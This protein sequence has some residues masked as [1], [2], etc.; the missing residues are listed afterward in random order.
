MQTD[1]WPLLKLRKSIWRVLIYIHLFAN[2]I[3]STKTFD[4]ISIFVILLNSLMM[5][6][7]DPAETEPEKIFVLIDNIF[8]TLYSIEM[9]LKIVGLG[10][11]FSKKAY[12]KESWNILDFVIVISGYL[13]LWTESN[14]KD[15]DTGMEVGEKK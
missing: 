8:L 2:A 5:M 11:I 3:I 10:L 14:Q 12:L 15:E 13:T 7:E 6:I 1:K 9:V 4:N